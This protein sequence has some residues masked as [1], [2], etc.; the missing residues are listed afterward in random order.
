VFSH[1]IEVGIQKHRPNIQNIPDASETLSKGQ[2]IEP[3]RTLYIHAE[4]PT[5][6]SARNRSLHS[7][8][9]SQAQAAPLLAVLWVLCRVK[10]VKATKFI[11]KFGTYTLLLDYFKFLAHQFCEKCSIL[12][13][14]CRNWSVADWK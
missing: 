4:H 2:I 8:T 1:R 7:K 12:V 6:K 3:L 13:S 14:R 10:N 11:G 5:E 9:L